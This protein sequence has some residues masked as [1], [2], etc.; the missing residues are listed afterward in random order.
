MWPAIA[1][2][3][4]ALLEIWRTHANKPEGWVPSAQDWADLGVSV[5]ESTPEN[6]KAAARARLGIPPSPPA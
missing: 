6:E 3:M 5:D 1:T 4:S 2:G